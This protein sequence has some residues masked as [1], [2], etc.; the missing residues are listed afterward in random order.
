MEAAWFTPE[1]GRLLW[2]DYLSRQQLQSQLTKNYPQRRPIDEPSPHRVFVLNT[3][4][5]T[6]PP[7]A[8]LRVIGVEVVGGRTALKVEKPTSTNGE[9][10]FNGPYPIEAPADAVPG[11]P[12]EGETPAVDPVPEKL[13]VGWAYRYG[14]VVMLG[15]PPSEPNVS[16]GPIVDSWEIEEG[17]GPFTVFGEYQI[18]PESETAALIGRFAGGGSD[19]LDGLVS[20]SH[21]CGLYTIELGKITED[22]DSGSQSGSGIDCDPCTQAGS[23]SESTSDC[24]LT[25]LSPIP[26]VIGSGVFILAYD[27]QS[28]TV[29]L[30][31]GTDCV[32]GKVSGVSAGSSS[33]SGS[34]AES[35][36]GAAG[37]TPWRVVRGYQEHLV[38]YRE[39]WD[40]CEP[41]G[42]PVLIG[43]TPIIFPGIECEEIIC[44]ECPP[45]SG[46]G[47]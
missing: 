18:T 29:P 17:G 34:A 39:R 6:I 47:V 41:D 14:V 46:S 3:T 40:C 23:A 20:I 7:F 38:Q 5:E 8:C 9:F 31:P 15:N 33:G 13:G 10:L 36:S 12:A 43:R 44:G 37:F 32:V 35:G 24:T 2:Q 27:P 30:K 19:I 16:Y 26:K 1:Q 22:S 11:V 4:E 45:S 21:G 25:L 28:I 42:P